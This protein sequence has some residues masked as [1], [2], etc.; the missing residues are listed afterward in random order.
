MKIQFPPIL[1]TAPRASRGP[2]GFTLIELLVVISIVAVLLALLLPTL[3]AAREAARGV[4]CLSNLRQIGLS[5]A[6]YVSDHDQRVIPAKTEPNYDGSGS[7]DLEDASWATLLTLGEYTS[8]PTAPSL[9]APLQ[10]SVFTCPTATLKRC[11]WSVGMAPNQNCLSGLGAGNVATSHLA[12]PDQGTDAGGS[13]VFLD[14]HYGINARDQVGGSEQRWPFIVLP[15]QFAS[16]VG[17][18]RLRLI[19]QIEQ[20]QELVAIYDGHW[21]LDAYLG[22]RIQTRHSGLT[23]TNILMLDS[24]AEAVKASLL[25]TTYGEWKNSVFHPRW[26]VKQ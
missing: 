22:N 12:H 15:Q 25:P 9:G 14:N 17:F 26:R 1:H 7:T 19:D 20:P 4:T 10:P 18:D 16:N 13:T 5:H 6:M 21:V 24:H 8:A 11:N 2:G 3:G 23:T